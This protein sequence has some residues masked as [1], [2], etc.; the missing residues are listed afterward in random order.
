MT[1]I[2]R[3]VLAV[4]LAA[5][6]LLAVQTSDAQTWPDRPVSIIVP[7]GAGGGTDA[8]ARL[9]AKQLQDELRQP[10]N[11]VNQPQA[12]GLVGHTN[13]S[14]ARPD[15]YTLGIIYPY[16]QFNLSGQSEIN[17][18][19]FQPI[20]LYNIDSSAF[21][22]SA[23]SPHQTAQAA[24]AQIRA[25]PGRVRISC[26]GSCGGSWDL[27]FAGLLVKLGVDPRSIVFVPSGGAAPGLQELVAGSVDMIAASL[28]EAAALIGAN[29]VR[30]LMVLA[31]ERAPAFAD[32]P[33][34]REAVGQDH[35]GG[36]WRAVAGPPGLPADIVQRMEST[37]ERIWRSDEFQN[38]MRQRG[39]GL[40]WAG[41]RDTVAFMQQHE[42]DWTEAMNA[43]GM[44]RRA[45]PR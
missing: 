9:L 39:F 35:A 36:A 30:P 15:G 12:S 44:N 29:R 38:A 40:R 14:Q 2:K 17:Y 23:S 11:I 42:R 19:S 33:T 3:R 26:G 32:V 43:L 16:F 22:V 21:L 27:P 34:A 20:A 41:S 25:N 7:A 24:L 6:S 45:A 8:T 37:L 4:A 31:T 5:A 13:I 10:F 18:R 1:S 28:P